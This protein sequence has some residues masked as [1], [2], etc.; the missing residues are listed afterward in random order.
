MKNIIAII[1]VVIL[2]AVPIVGISKYNS[3]IGKNET[4]SEN[5]GAIQVQYQRRADLIPNLVKAVRSYAKYENETLKSII[6]AR[7]ALLDAKTPAEMSKA[8]SMFRTML[9]SI[10]AVAEQ[11]PQLKANETYSNLM[12]ELAGTENR[13]AVARDNYNDAVKQY[14]YAIKTVFGKIFATYMDMH[15]C[16]Y[17]KASEGTSSVVS[18]DL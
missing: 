9:P 15:A 3:I 2:L 4:V 5:L 17:V 18:I 14:N 11:Y 12:L 7:N 13:V 6:A 16:E 10:T 1:V 8:D